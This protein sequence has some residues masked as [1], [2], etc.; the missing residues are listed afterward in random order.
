M[1]RVVGISSFVSLVCS[2]VYRLIFVLAASDPR[3]LQFRANRAAMDV[4]CWVF[5]VVSLGIF[6]RE[7]IVLIAE[8]K[9]Q[10]ASGKCLKDAVFNGFSKV[11]SLIL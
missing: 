5:L 7:S 6:V 11:F 10:R 3:Y 1:F 9:K 2:L 4:F 8:I